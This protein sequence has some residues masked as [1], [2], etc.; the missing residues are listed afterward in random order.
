MT[1]MLNA[2]I[3]AGALPETSYGLNSRYYGRPVVE[4]TRPDGTVIR[5]V[6]RRFI[7]QAARFATLVAHP[8]QLGDRIDVLAARYLGDTLLYWRI[9]DANL[10]V[11]PDDP[12]VLGKSINIPLAASIPGGLP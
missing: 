8:V 5:Y 6:K 9:C 2:L 4:L 12:V 1:D 3:A 7:P 11:R 10:A